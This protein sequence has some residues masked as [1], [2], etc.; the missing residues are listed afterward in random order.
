MLMRKTFSFLLV[1]LVVLSLV[2]CSTTSYNTPAKIVNF[3][4]VVTNLYRSGQLTTSNQWAYVASLGVT[5]DIKLNTDKEGSDN[6]AT[7]YG[8]KVVYLP[9]PPSGVWDWWKAPNEKEY[10]RAILEIKDSLNRGEG[11]LVHCT[12][13]QDR[14]GIVMGGT[15]IYVLHKSKQEAW[16]NMKAHNYHVI[17]LGLDCFWHKLPSY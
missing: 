7:N 13:G 3:E 15:D 16:T 11:V 1:L 5:K 17:F 4:Q 12:H 8:I 9:M 6:I 2:G 14:T 10:F